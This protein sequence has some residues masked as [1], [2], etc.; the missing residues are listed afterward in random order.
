MKKMRLL[1]LLCL[2]VVVIPSLKAQISIAPTQLN[3]F[4]VYQGSPD[5][6]SF[7]ITNTKTTGDLIVS[8]LHFYHRETFSLSDSV[9]I[10]QPGQSKTIWVR[11]NPRHNIRYI[12]WITLETSTEAI[13][14]GVFVFAQGK[15]TETYYDAT[16]NLWDESLETALKTLTGTA[17]VNLGYNAAR[18]AIFMNVDN[19][20]VNGQGA[21]VNTLECI[22][23]GRQAVGYTSRTDC[24][25]NH[26]FNTEHTMPQAFFGSASPMVADMH[27]LFPTDDAAN[28]ERG[29]SPFGMVTNPSWS[30]GGSKSNGNVFEPRD[31]HKGKAAR[32]L[33]YFYTRYQDYSGFLAG[34]QNLLRQWCANFLPDSVEKK[35]NSDIYTYYQHNRNPYIDH[36]EFLERITL[37]VGTGVRTPAPIAKL[38][39]GFL[40][41]TSPFPGNQDGYFLVSNEGT[42]TLTISNFSFSNPD[43]ALIGSPNPVIPP[44]SARK[45]WIRLTPSNGGTLYNETVSFSTNDALRPSLTVQLLGE[46]LVGMEDGILDYLIIYPQPADG[47]LQLRWEDGRIESG[48]LR[49]I[50][51]Q[52]QVLHTLALPAGA[53]SVSLD[54]QDVAAGCYLLELTKNGRTSVHKVVLE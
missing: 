17:Y 50:S 49:L 25:N 21:A 27:H 32:A 36:P 12:D 6:A 54:V 31:A 44:D 41:Y 46:S 16:L 9:F 24:Q 19:Q 11:C 39:T 13:S 1:L 28:S 15:Y 14:P 23:T 35:R 5:S 4:S 53:S 33:L 20:R 45:V 47:Q 43:Y 30:V 37:L 51:L 22:Y 18:D 40:T 48:R 29:N 42:D 2:G 38:G 34:Q 8:N 26:S 7:T 52:G 3:L 10:L